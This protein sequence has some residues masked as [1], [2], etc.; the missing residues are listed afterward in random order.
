MNHQ[1][2]GG[3]N[4][5]QFQ[6][7]TPQQMKLHQQQFGL[8]DPNSYLYRMAQGDPQL[9][10]EMERRNLR[11]F[12]GTMGN[13]ASRFSGAGMSG[14]HSS[15]FKIAGGMEARQLQ[16]SLAAQ[17][18]QMQSQAIKDMIGLS[19]QILGQDPNEQ[20]LVE[21]K[22]QWW[23]HAVGGIAP[24]AGAAIGAKYGGLEG[25]KFGHDIGS[26]FGNA[27]AGGR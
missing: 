2:V 26:G 9:M 23:Q 21:P 7:Y 17:R 10:E 3:R 20:F 24:L 14:R 5:E 6:K 15:G 4:V 8:L 25:A 27:F 1:K 16:E 19:N 13:M 22:K 11:D 18:G 12:S